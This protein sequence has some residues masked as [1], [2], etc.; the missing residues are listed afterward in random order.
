[1]NKTTLP[2]CFLLLLHT[3]LQAQTS[4]LFILAGH[5]E[6]VNIC[7]FSPD[8]KTL[9]SGSKDGVL[10]VWDV[11]A[12]YK[13]LKEIVT[14]DD[15][16]T[17]LNFSHAGDRFAAGT[18]NTLLI[19]DSKTYKTLAKKKKAH[20]SFVKSASFS[21][22]DK[23]IVSSSWK[24]NALMVWES[25]KLKKVNQLSESIWTDDAFF[26]EDGKYIISCNH[27]DVAKA[28]DAQT[29]NIVKTFAG[30]KDWIYAVQLTGNMKTLITG[31]FDK[32]IKLWDFESG[33]LLNTLSG[34]REGISTLAL[35]PDNRLIASASI[36]GSIVLWDLQKQQELMRLSEKGSSVLHLEFSPDSKT[37]LSCSADHTLSVWD[38]TVH[39]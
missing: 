21:P 27:D 35:S 3:L 22:D 25:T 33:Q 1:M 20:S 19:F 16:I 5:Q 18:L 14:G 38:V 15:A 6:G 32:T 23:L 9:I 30:H 37:L 10:K 17:A 31:S 28:W 8:G 39:P 24:E 29:G 11:A 2:I 12:R 34:H 7:A 4:P 26:T 13:P 36:D